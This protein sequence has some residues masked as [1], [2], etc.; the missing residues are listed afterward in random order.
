MVSII[1]PTRDKHQL[2]KKCVD[3]ILAKTSYPH[4]EI[5][6]LDNGSSE[7]EAVHYLDNINGGPDHGGQRPIPV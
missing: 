1:I 3:S 6:I 7:K 5:I 2:L 4:Y